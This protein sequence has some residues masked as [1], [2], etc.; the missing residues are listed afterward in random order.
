MSNDCVIFRNRLAPVLAA[1]QNRCRSVFGVVCQMSVSCTTNVGSYVTW[2]CHLSISP[3]TGSGCQPEPVQVGFRGRMSDG[4]ASV[5]VGAFSW[6]LEMLPHC[7]VLSRL[8]LS[9]PVLSCLVLSC[10]VLSCP[11]YFCAVMFRHVLPSPVPSCPVYKPDR[12]NI[13]CMSCE[14]LLSVYAPSTLW[15]TDVHGRHL[16]CCV[17]Q[18]IVSDT[19]RH[20]G[21]YTQTITTAI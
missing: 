13:S 11:V 21:P 20:T 15:E 10:P 14:A 19:Y 2:L 4:C 12:Q 16:V 8:V 6:L 9:S 3:C 1:S 5:P 18:R 17:S 7:P